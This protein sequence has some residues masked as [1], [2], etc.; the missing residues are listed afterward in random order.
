M[1]KKKILL[2]GLCLALTF[3]AIGVV[4]SCEEDKNEIID[5]NISIIGPSELDVGQTTVLVARAGGVN[6][7]GVTWT[8]SD[9]KVAIIDSAL[10][11]LTTISAG[12]TTI[13]CTKPG[14]IAAT[15][16][17]TVKDVT[18]PNLIIINDAEN[19]T[20]K[21][22]ETLTLKLRDSNGNDVND[23][24][25]TSSDP[26]VALVS[27]AGLVSGR[28]EGSA[29]I[30]ASKQGFNSATFTVKVEASE[31]TPPEDVY[32]ISYKKQSGVIFD[33]PTSAKAG[34][35]VSFTVNATSS[36]I[37]I[38]EVRVNGTVKNK[39]N[40]CYTF[41]MPSESV[42][43]EASIMIGDAE[44]SVGGDA[45]FPLVPNSE[46][47]YESDPITLE[48]DSHLTFYVN[49]DG[50]AKAL[51]YRDPSTDQY[52]FDF[53]E[54]FAHIEPSGS[55]QFKLDGG[56]SYIFYYNPTTK[57]C[58]VRRDQ[59]VT[60][61]Q[62]GNQLETLFD[63]G[64][65]TISTYPENVSKVTYRNS[66]T[67]E[68]YVW[69]KYADNVSIASV[70][71]LSTGTDGNPVHVGDVYKAIE[72][73]KLRVVDTYV[74]TSNYQTT[75]HDIDNDQRS[76]KYSGLYNIY[77]TANEFPANSSRYSYTREDAEFFANMYSHDYYSLELDFYEAYRAS[78][79]IED[80]LK[81]AS[82][83]VSS[84]SNISG[85]FTTTVDSY[86][87][88]VDS[89][90]ASNNVHY[91][92]DLSITFDAKGRMLSGKYTI[93]SFKSDAYDF[94][95]DKFL[96]GGQTKGTI[97]KD[98][99]WSYEYNETLT[100]APSFDYDKYFIKNITSLRVNNKTVNTDDSKNVIKKGDIIAIDRSFV[101][102]E[103]K[104]EEALDYWQYG[105]VASS[106]TK[107]IASRNN[108]LGEYEAVGFGSSTLTFG[109][110][111]T[112]SVLYDVTVDVIA[113]I[114]PF[115][116]FFNCTGVNGNRVETAHKVIV[117]QGESLD[118]KFQTSPSG[119][120]NTITDR[121]EL[122]DNRFFTVT[123]DSAKEILHIVAKS[124]AYNYDVPSTGVEV[125]MNIYS[126]VYKSGQTPCSVNKIVVMPGGPFSVSQMTGT[127]KNE[128]KGYTATFTTDKIKI[129]TT[130][131]NKGTIVAGKETLVI[132]WTVEDN[133]Y[134]DYK[135]ASYS[136]EY[137]SNSPSHLFEICFTDDVSVEQE[138][139]IAWSMTW[140][141]GL[142]DISQVDVIGYIYEAT[143]DEGEYF[144]ALPFTKQA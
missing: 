5:T 69:N 37:E 34:E 8:S 36:S 4:T 105:V 23:A 140:W 43:V 124:D 107:V 41:T 17:I 28:S 68:D 101:T 14:Y 114:E 79:T 103:Y 32:S 121:I 117:Y 94:S 85:G 1:K 57:R 26:N 116:W 118:F 42:L 33:G 64:A 99:A 38:T 84:V 56:Y 10:G 96:I 29:T 122:S 59:V 100:T 77:E 22:G 126:S 142:D 93:E 119:S 141:G 53:R 78:F 127:W 97:T 19:S 88:Y 25:W 73:N 129:G 95:N 3:G 27:Q 74:E 139:D 131:W 86:K 98:I 20:I 81:F 87:T 35:T 71:T 143:E 46:G 40:D 54:C 82:L 134:L 90:N 48:T 16:T 123:Y 83:E 7:D 76:A 24:K 111:T 15:L 9:K 50:E 108:S 2:T 120:D 55:E 51:K 128:A 112:N 67:N 144:D 21:Q 52:A 130:T 136:G 133:G 65:S 47:I 6:L 106:D 58:Y 45:T 62:T 70:Q 44:V 115:Y 60:L 11:D 91:E 49:V 30:T 89:S 18:L 66:K 135:V 110:H 137:A 138:I 80:S 125:T 13:T 113:G 12:S 132:G 102:F 39:I 63:S 31:V 61:P 109:N 104:E 92:Y 72:G 75:D